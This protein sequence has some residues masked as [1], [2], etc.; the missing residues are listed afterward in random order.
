MTFFPKITKACR[1]RRHRQHIRQRCQQSILLT[2][3][4]RILLEMKSFLVANYSKHCDSN[5]FLIKENF[6]DFRENWRIFPKLP[7]SNKLIKD[8]ILM[9]I[10]NAVAEEMGGVKS[11]LTPPP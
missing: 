6:N 3:K 7:T 4:N 8:K 5:H 10:S 2:Q 1:T 11:F 9:K